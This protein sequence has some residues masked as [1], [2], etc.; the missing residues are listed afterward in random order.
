MKSKSK[1]EPVIISN[2]SVTCYADRLVIHLYYFP[3]GSKTIKYEDI[4][5]CQ[6]LPLRRLNRLKYKKWGM[7]LSPIWWHSD[8]QRYYRNY[9]LLL[10]TNHWPY[11]GVTMDDKDILN[12]FELIQS[13]AQSKFLSGPANGKEMKYRD[14]SEY[15]SCE[16]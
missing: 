3:Y 13:G 15:E 9:Y 14:F 1:S 2:D 11:I 5:S 4:R 12:V 8:V 16:Q 6:L 10:D 7:G